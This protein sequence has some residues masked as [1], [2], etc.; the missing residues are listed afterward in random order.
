MTESAFAQ[1]PMTESALAQSPPDQRPGE[2]TILTCDGAGHVLVLS[3]AGVFGDSQGVAG[4]GWFG[5]DTRDNRGSTRFFRESLFTRG[6][7]YY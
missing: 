5:Q 1:S 7:P 2:F 3:G 4:G 6:A